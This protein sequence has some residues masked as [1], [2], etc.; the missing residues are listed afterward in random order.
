MSWNRKK[1]ISKSFAHSCRDNYYY[2]LKLNGW[3][4]NIIFFEFE[5]HCA[6]IGNSLSLR[7]IVLGLTSAYVIQPPPEL[8]R[9]VLVLFFIAFWSV[10]CWRF[11]IFIVYIVEIHAPCTYWCGWL[12]CW[13]RID[14]FWFESNLMLW[15]WDIFH[16]GQYMIATEQFNWIE[17][18]RNFRINQ[19]Q[20]KMTNIITECILTDCVRPQCAR[21]HRFQRR[22]NYLQYIQKWSI[23][24]RVELV[25]LVSLNE[26]N[27]KI[28]KI[29]CSFFSGGLY[30]TPSAI[31][32]IANRI[33]LANYSPSSQESSSPSTK[34]NLFNVF[35]TTPAIKS[36]NSNFKW[37]FEK[38]D[39]NEKKTRRV[40][41]VCS[42][43]WRAAS[44]SWC[45][46]RLMTFRLN[47]FWWKMHTEKINESVTRWWHYKLL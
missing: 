38:T 12:T 1:K 44:R 31:Q 34:L 15:R 45:G 39:C 17:T 26:L 27:E 24:F 10:V 37:Q 4:L 30:F 16:G 20:N 33:L 46:S 8:A 40:V 14:W 28:A 21:I 35:S 7:E 11:F 42:F 25:Q 19:R 41:L 23:Q 5:C 2:Y 22:R 3:L 13:K 18:N 9:F 47:R 32:D 36:Q 6:R 43:S 29:Y